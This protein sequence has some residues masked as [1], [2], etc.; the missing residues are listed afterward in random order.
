MPVADQVNPYNLQPGGR[1]GAGRFRYGS[2]SELKLERQ[3]DRARA[4][5][6]VERVEA[7]VGTA[8]AEAARQGLRRLAEQRA[9]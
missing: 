1:V 3:L 8:G 5:N 6:L 9:G 7:S 4:A 2:L